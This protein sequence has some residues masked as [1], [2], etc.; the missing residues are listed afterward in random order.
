MGQARGAR[1]RQGEPHRVPAICVQE[2]AMKA[3]P[4]KLRF[5]RPCDVWIDEALTEIRDTGC[6]KTLHMRAR[7]PIMRRGRLSLVQFYRIRI[8]LS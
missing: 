6:P 2:V 5:N 1:D 8:S 3:E 4:G 7:A